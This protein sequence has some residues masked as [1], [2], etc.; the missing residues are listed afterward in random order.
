MFLGIFATME[1]HGQGWTENEANVIRSY[2]L[3]SKCSTVVGVE[4]LWH[5]LRFFLAPAAK[6]IKSL[7]KVSSKFY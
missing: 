7:R 6:C 4:W 3:H 1:D 5:G 2:G